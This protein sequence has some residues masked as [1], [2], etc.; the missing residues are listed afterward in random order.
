MNLRAED[1]C[2]YLQG[3]WVGENIYQST[4]GTYSKYEIHRNSNGT[5]EIYFQFTNSDGVYKKE[6]YVGF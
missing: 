5:M 2:G 3:K 4:T 6:K 1:I